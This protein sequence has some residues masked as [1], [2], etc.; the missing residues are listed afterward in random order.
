MY[1]Y[2]FTRQATKDLRKLPKNVQKTIVKKLDYF[3]NSAEPL[4]FATYLINSEIGQY[5]FRI[6]DYRV[7]FDLE[8][9]IL[10]I[11]TLGHRKE[12]YR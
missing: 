4:Q 5:R 7:I 12:I 8:N 6:G 11:L 3:I 10:I 2:E 9:E 1:S